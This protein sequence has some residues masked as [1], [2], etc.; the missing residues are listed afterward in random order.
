[1]H[2]YGSHRCS[3][4]IISATRLLTAAQCTI[5]KVAGGIQYRVGS[6]DSRSGGQ[7]MYV[8][9]I[10][11]HPE[12]NPKTLSNDIAVVWLKKQINFAMT[13]VTLLSLPETNERVEVET[14]TVIS[15][16][17]RGG[18]E[19]NL[20]K[21]SHMSTISNELCNR[22]FRGD[23]LDSML[24]A[25]VPVPDGHHV[26]E[27]SVDY[28]Q[29]DMGGPVANIEKQIVVGVVV[30]GHGGSKQDRPG[31]YTRVASYREWIDSVM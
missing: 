28:Y 14:I 9:A 11:N 16:W 17:E 10:I 13:G 22:Y 7:Y 4:T 21:Y 29:T 6:R 20:M 24:C 12:Y 5:D 3:A 19:P 1:M 15:G 25:E 8:E 27:D 18:L 23:V 31:V 30:W 2:V 26:R